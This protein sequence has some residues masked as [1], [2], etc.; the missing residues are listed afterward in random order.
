MPKEA[1]G[2]AKAGGKNVSL[3]TK[4]WKPRQKPIYGSTPK[5]TVTP[6]AVSGGDVRHAGT[7]Q[8]HIVGHRGDDN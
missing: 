8:T 7:R 2:F 5:T 6:R 1:R 4:F 3:S